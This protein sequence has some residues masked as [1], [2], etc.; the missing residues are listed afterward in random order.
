MTIEHVLLVVSCVI[1]V[2]QQ[3]FF[4]WQVNKLVNKAMSRDFHSYAQTMTPPKPKDLGGFHIQL[5]EQ[6]GLDRLKEL[7]NSLNMP[8]F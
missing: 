2:F 4:M 8:G 7:N 3:V 1:I 5:P 6:E